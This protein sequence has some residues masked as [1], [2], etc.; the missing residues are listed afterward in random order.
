MRNLAK[1]ALFAALALPALLRASIRLNILDRR[2]PLDE[3]ARRMANVGS[4]RLPV[5]CNPRY[6]EACVQRFAGP[7]PPRRFGPCLKRSYL[8]LDLWSR[9][10]LRPRIHLGAAAADDGGRNFHAWITVPSDQA[11]SVPAGYTELWS[12]PGPDS[13]G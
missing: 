10:G 1:K 4:W 7:L 3:V 12:H 6:L 9:C 5:L 2:H 8:L 13:H 11:A